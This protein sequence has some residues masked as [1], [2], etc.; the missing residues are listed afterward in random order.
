M[1]LLVNLLRGYAHNHHDVRAASD[2][3]VLWPQPG[4]I[5]TGGHGI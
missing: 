2:I 3:D 5:H 4:Q 1:R